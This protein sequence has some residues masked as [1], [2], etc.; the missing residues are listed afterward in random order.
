M[1]IVSIKGILIPV[2]TRWIT[3]QINLSLPL[4]SDSSSRT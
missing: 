4:K 1:T 2:Y 3:S